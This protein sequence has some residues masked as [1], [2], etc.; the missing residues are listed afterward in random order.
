MAWCRPHDWSLASANVGAQTLLF[1]H[2]RHSKDQWQ[3]KINNI[4]ESTV[5][6]KNI[7]NRWPHP[8]LRI[9][10]CVCVGAGVPILRYINISILIKYSNFSRFHKKLG[11]FYKQLRWAFIKNAKNWQTRC[12][13]WRNDNNLDNQF[14]QPT[15]VMPKIYPR[16]ASDISKICPR[17]VQDM[18]KECPRYARGMPEISPRYALDISP[19]N[20]LTTDLE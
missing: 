4:R 3:S 17:S 12:A 2:I 1:L 19:M 14:W 15:Q 10:F 20:I 7:R 6:K 9:G 8:L 13:S 11:P 5:W 18:P 16:Y